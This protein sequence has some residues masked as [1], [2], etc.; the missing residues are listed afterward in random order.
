M[1][2]G[3]KSCLK[4]YGKNP[5]KELITTNCGEMDIVY[6]LAKMMNYDADCGGKQSTI[7]R[8]LQE[9]FKDYGEGDL[10]VET[11]LFR[12]LEV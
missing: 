9:N 1:L 12:K 2:L 10:T 4:K 3:I 5:P 11:L 7:R 8:M 6:E